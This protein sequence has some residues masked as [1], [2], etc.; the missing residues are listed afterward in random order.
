MSKKEQQQTKP[1]E[2]VG[3]RALSHDNLWTP[4]QTCL[5]LGITPQE[6]GKYRAEGM[7][8][9][10]MDDD[11]PRPGELSVKELKSFAKSLEE[12]PAATVAAWLD[13]SL[14]QLNN[15]VNAGVIQRTGAGVKARFNW[16]AVWK[17]WL[18]YKTKQARGRCRYCGH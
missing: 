15:L 11:D 14:R 5:V 18:E 2:W 10:Y 16:Y 6:L 12:L 17:S 1:S 8:C 9:H 7:P 4:L 13:I 3:S